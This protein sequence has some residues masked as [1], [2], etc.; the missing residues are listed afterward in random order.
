MFCY[1]LMGKGLTPVTQ[2]NLVQKPSSHDVCTRETKKHLFIN[3]LRHSNTLHATLLH[4]I[5]HT[6]TYYTYDYY[7]RDVID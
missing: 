2:G 4:I 7:T 6:F 5:R 1:E 3:Y